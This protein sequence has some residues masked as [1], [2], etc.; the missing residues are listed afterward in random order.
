VGLG[1]TFNKVP[2]CRLQ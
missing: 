1:D 2:G